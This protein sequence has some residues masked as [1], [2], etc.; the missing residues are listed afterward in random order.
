M[1]ILALKLIN[2]DYFL[3]RPILKLHIYIFLIH[4]CILIEVRKV[5]NIRA[6]LP[7][8]PLMW[9]WNCWELVE[10]KQQSRFK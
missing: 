4:Q 8:L 7:P 1:T 9:N 2:I 5:N 6:R 3:L 10:L